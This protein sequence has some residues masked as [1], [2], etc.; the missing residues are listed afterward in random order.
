MSKIQNKS[1]L[2]IFTEKPFEL[3]QLVRKNRHNANRS[4]NE[5]YRN[6]KLR[7]RLVSKN[8]K[9]ICDF[10][11]FSTQTYHKAIGLIDAVSSKFLFDDA[12]FKKIS[13]V[14]LGLVS[15]TQ[16]STDKALYTNSLQLIM[17][18]D[19]AEYARLEKLVLFA[20]EFDLNL[21]VPYE[22][23]VEMLRLRETFENINCNLFKRFRKFVLRM[24]HKTALEYENNKFTSLAVALAIVISAREVF[25]CV[26]PLPAR[27]ESLTGY[28]ESVLSECLEEIRP[29]AQKLA[30]KKDKK[31]CSF[32]SESTDLS[33]A[34]LSFD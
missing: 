23:I 20:M 11:D 32:S 2:P 30:Q 3:V 13:L 18:G 15:K 7:D 5:D 25:G 9:S 34:D 28:S 19:K 12:M 1:N 6:G 21:T 8:L 16:E 31:E 22:Y 4:Y 29:V 10:L 17:P 33:S 14:C 26:E 24:T 27:L